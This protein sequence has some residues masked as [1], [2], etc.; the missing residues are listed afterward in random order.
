MLRR[1]WCVRRIASS[2][3]E[4]GPF[5]SGL[6]G[7]CQWISTESPIGRGDGH[8]ESQHLGRD[9]DRRKAL[10][11]ISWKKLISDSEIKA[12]RRASLVVNIDVVSGHELPSTL[13]MTNG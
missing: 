13:A 6:H 3:A 12:G 4:R 2:G 10:T 9:G 8:L 11:I 5:F 1:R 7:V